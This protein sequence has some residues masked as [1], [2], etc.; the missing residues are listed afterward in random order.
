MKIEKKLSNLKWTH[1]FVATS[2]ARYK[3]RTRT[4]RRLSH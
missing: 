4:G 2:L 3:T 1:G